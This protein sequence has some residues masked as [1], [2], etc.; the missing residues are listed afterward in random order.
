[1]LGRWRALTHKYAKQGMPNLADELTKMFLGDV[2]N[3][4][5]VAGSSTTQTETLIARTRDSLRAIVDAAI[6]L[7]TAINEDVISCDYETVLIH[8]SDM[9][10]PANMEDAFPDAKPSSAPNAKNVLCTAGLGLRCC[11]KREGNANTQWEVTVLQK[12]QVILQSAIGQ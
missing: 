10:D 2:R 9:F 8:P 7:R 3:L 5:V 11:R 6:R 12:P 1:M 4:F